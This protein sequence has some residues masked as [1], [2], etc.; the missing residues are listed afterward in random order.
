MTTSKKKTPDCS[1]NIRL[2]EYYEKENA[3][4]RA[5]SDK[6][7]IGRTQATGLIKNKD[8]VLKLWKSKG[9]DEMKT[10][11]RRKTKSINNNI[12]NVVYEWFLQIIVCVFGFF[13]HS[14]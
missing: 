8:T 6:F 9:N 4:S 1:R 13:M 14:I 10:K 3:S 7:L 11:K 5:L 12:N 2:L